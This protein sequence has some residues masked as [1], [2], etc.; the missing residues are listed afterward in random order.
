MLYKIIFIAIICIFSSAL[1]KKYNSEISTLVSVCGG[2]LIFVLSVQQLTLVFN[3]LKDIYNFTD[4]NFDFLKIIFKVLAV[5]YITEFAADI[6]DD[7]GNSIISSKVIFGG[8]LVICG[9]T[10]PVVKEL[11]EMLLSLL[12]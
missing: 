4:L 7:F 3:S 12:S 2:V 10:L 11:L 6:A 1:L 9:M 5:G 8:K